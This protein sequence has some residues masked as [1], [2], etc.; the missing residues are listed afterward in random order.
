[1]P[2]PHEPGPHWG[3]VG[4]HG[5]H[6]QREWDA[7]VA[8]ELPDAE[9]GEASFVA[10][11]DGSVRAESGDA[12]P[13]VFAAAISLG[14]PFRARAV[15]L[16]RSTWAVGARRIETV[17]LVDD[18]AGDEIEIA[19]DG[20]ERTVRIGGAPTLAGVPALERLAAERHR[21][22]VVRAIRLAGTTWELSVSPL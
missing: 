8:L 15:R 5:V 2:L 19:W 21:A 16:G 20:A 17:E 1:V 10:L 6:R 22:Y 12:D 18:P 3:E 9:G 14:P 4:I 13:S 11:E 7:V